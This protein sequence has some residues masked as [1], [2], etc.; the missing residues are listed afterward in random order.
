[1]H[2]LVHSPTSCKDSIIVVERLDNSEANMVSFLPILLLKGNGGT[3]LMHVKSSFE[4]HFILRRY[5]FFYPA[6]RVKWGKV[7]ASCF[8]PMIDTECT[9][10][11][12][13]IC[14]RNAFTE[15]FT[16]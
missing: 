7:K 8:F 5:C 15:T 6:N 10:W 16:P 13:M 3:W 1:M 2:A 11:E 14:S 12:K 9:E 4:T